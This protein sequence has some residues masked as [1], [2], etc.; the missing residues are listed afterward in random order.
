MIIIKTTFELQEI[1]KNEEIY[2]PEESLS[3]LQKGKFY[4]CG[5]GENH[6]VAK[7]SIGGACRGRSIAH[8]GVGKV[9]LIF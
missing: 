5:C 8:S 2:P 6:E 3:P 1:I 4:K 7:T 9:G